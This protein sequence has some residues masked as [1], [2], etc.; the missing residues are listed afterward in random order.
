MKIEKI[1]GRTPEEIKAKAVTCTMLKCSECPYEK[2][3]YFC[4]ANDVID[5]LLA[6]VK[7]LEAQLPKWISVQERLP[8]AIAESGRVKTTETVFAMDS[9]GAVHVGYFTVYKYDGS[10]VFHGV[11]VELFDESPSDITHWM[12]LPEPQEEE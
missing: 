3:E 12:P 10:N 5:N 7:H 1:N 4:S 2:E 6:Y 9:C 8:D 11:D